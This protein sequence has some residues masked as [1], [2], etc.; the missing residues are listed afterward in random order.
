MRKPATYGRQGFVIGKFNIILSQILQKYRSSEL[1]NYISDRRL[2]E[3]VE[4]LENS[5]YTGDTAI[6]FIASLQILEAW[7]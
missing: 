3:S 1:S 7:I 6:F 2:T 4:I 5:R